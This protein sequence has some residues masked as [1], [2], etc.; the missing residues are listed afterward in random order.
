VAIKPAA[1]PAGATKIA[2]VNGPRVR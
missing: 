2:N 1:T